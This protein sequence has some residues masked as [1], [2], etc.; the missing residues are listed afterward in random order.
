VSVT[1]SI[2]AR[3]K[4]GAATGSIADMIDKCVMKGVSELPPVEGRVY[5]AFVVQPPRPRF[6]RAG[7]QGP[8]AI[9][10][11]HYDSDRRQYVQD[12]CGGDF[13]VAE[14]AGHL[15]RYRITAVTGLDSDSYDETGMAEA[16]VGLIAELAR[17]HP[18]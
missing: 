18:Q 12:Y 1:G 2:K 14:A 17:E 11:G 10:I 16:S 3:M 9:A 8:C 4:G 15:K 5:R 13:T 6:E 7:S